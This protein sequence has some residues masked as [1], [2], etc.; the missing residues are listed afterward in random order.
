MGKLKGGFNMWKYVKKL[1]YP[2][3]ITKKDLNMAKNMMAQYGG[4]YLKRDKLFSH[5]KKEPA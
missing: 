4:P 2:I 5:T 1:E 3:N